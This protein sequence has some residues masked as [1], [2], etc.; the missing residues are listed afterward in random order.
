[1]QAEDLVLYNCSEGE[2]IKEFSE[3]FPHV[4]ISVF[5]QAFIV[6]TIDLS[7]LSAF[8]IST[9]NGESVFIADFECYEQGYCL[10]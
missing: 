3:V 10:N 6:E 2:V 4:G 9:Q 7:N 1:M 5:P 8:V